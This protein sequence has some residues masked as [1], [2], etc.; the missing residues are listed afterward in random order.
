MKKT[1]VILAAALPLFLLSCRYVPE[2]DYSAI[3]NKKTYAPFESVNEPILLPFDLDLAFKQKGNNNS[4]TVKRYCGDVYA[5]YDWENNK[6]Q[7]YFFSISEAYVSNDMMRRVQGKDGILY[8]ERYTGWTASQD[9]ISYIEAKNTSI[10][11][12][13]LNGKYIIGSFLSYNDMPQKTVPVIGDGFRFYDF[14]NERLSEKSVDVK[15]SDFY[16]A[17]DEDGNFWY[18]KKTEET[19]KNHGKSELIKIDGTSFDESEALITLDENEGA[20]YIEED[21]S[22][23]KEIY[24]NIMIADRNY[25]LM[26]K[27]KMEKKS[28]DQEHNYYYWSS[29]EEGIEAFDLSTKTTK[30][31]KYPDEEVLEGYAN[32]DFIFKVNGIYYAFMVTGYPY[33]TKVFKYNPE[34]NSLQKVNATLDF[35]SYDA[36]LREKRIYFIDYDWNF[37]EDYYRL[38]CFDTETETFSQVKKLKLS[39]FAFED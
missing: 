29:E 36:T 17:I 5:I 10:E 33:V 7:D 26:A 18:L 11:K 34:T 9:Y 37:E 28:P 13:K 1:L 4:E 14:V 8:L 6:V 15:W 27:T 23:S 30:Y 39:D 35:T 22:W 32:T 38:A 25:V 21:K 3:L 12:L 2:R 24:R 20:S 19:D 31:V 16:P